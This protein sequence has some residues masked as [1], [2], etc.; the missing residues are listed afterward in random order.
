[1][2][3][4]GLFA[5]IFQDCPRVAFTISVDGLVDDEHG[6]EYE[7]G[8]RRAEGLAAQ[9]GEAKSVAESSQYEQSWKKKRIEREEI[10][11]RA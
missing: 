5:F 6:G 10:S 7:V 11:R 8:G 2:S 3:N 1:M 9:S 4:L